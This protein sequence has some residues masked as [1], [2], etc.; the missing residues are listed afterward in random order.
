MFTFNDLVQLSVED[1]AGQRGRAIQQSG[2]CTQMKKESWLHWHCPD[3]CKQN[4]HKTKVMQSPKQ[5]LAIKT[6]TIKEW[7]TVS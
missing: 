2:R 1:M 5:F 6:K 7:M 4:K 3:E